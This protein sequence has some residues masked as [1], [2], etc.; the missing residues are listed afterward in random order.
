MKFPILIISIMLSTYSLKSNGNSI[1]QTKNNVIPLTL[2]CSIYS[3]NFPNLKDAHI[4]NLQVTLAGNNVSKM[5]HQMV[6]KMGDY[7]FYVV[8]G[9]TLKKFNQLEIYSYSAEIR[10]TK[11]H[12]VAQ[13]RSDDSQDQSKKAIKIAKVAWVAYSSETKD[14]NYLLETSQLS[15]RCR[16]LTSH[17]KK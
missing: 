15:M 6:S 12:T 3:H 2:E 5:G 1:E 16:H 4:D 9:E 11:T 10:N 14:S 13:A 17:L 8:T 7:E